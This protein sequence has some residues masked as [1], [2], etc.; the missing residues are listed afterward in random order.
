PCLQ[1]GAPLPRLGGWL[2]LVPPPAPIAFPSDR[3]IS[4]LRPLGAFLS[5]AAA[6]SL[7]PAPWLPSRQALE[8]SGAPRDSPREAHA[9]STTSRRWDRSRRGFQDSCRHP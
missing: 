7:L 8:S 9:R 3:S 6:S 5:R 4:S 1:H 2:S